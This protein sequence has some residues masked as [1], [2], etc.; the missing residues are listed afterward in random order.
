MT[1][2]YPGLS[3]TRCS[4]SIDFRVSSRPPD[5]LWKVGVGP[6]LAITQTNMLPRR[7]TLSMS[8]RYRTTNPGFDRIW[9]KVNAYLVPLMR[10]S[11]ESKR[12][13]TVVVVY[14]SDDVDKSYDDVGHSFDDA[15]RISNNSRRYLRADRN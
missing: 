12:H 9:L 7:P 2:R 10:L 6:L 3:R 4:A 13:N 8:G 1:R 5:M 15:S 11:L 14:N